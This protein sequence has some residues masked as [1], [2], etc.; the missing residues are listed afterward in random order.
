[1]RQYD[2]I[3]TTCKIFGLYFA[4]QASVNIKD[5][6]VYGAGAHLYGA[7]D[8]SWYY[9]YGE[10]FFNLIFNGIAAWLLLSKSQFITSKIIQNTEDKIDLNIS[11]IDLI[12]LAVIIIAGLLIINSIP[13]ILNKLIHYIYFNPYD[14]IEKDR[15]WTSDSKADIFYSISKL[16]VGLL[17]ITRGRQISKLLTKLGEESDLAENENK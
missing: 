1:M 2:L 8:T 10:Q 15:F 7:E 6:F 5:I 4:V 16:A 3:K 9:F 17:T 13:E 11:K 14:K 12:E